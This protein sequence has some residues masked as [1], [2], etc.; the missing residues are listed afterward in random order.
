MVRITWIVM[1]GVW[2][3]FSDIEIPTLSP[4]DLDVL[5]IS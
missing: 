5:V 4:S 2:L 1:L 3:Y